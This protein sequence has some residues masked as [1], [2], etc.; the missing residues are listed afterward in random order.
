MSK[1]NF[2]WNNIQI[3]WEKPYDYIVIINCPPITIFPDVSNAILFQ[4]EPN[5][6][7]NRYMWGDWAEPPP[8]TFKYA[9][10][11]LH[12]YNNIEWHI[13]KTYTQLSEET[14]VKEQ[15][16][17]HI[18]STVLS[19][20]YKDP[21]HIKRIDFMKFLEKKGFNNVHVFGGN[22]FEWKNYM[23]SLPY[24]EKD[25]A[26]LPYK[27]VFNAENYEIRNYFTEKIV[28]GILSE[29]LVFYWGCPNIRDFIDERAYI[30]L[31]LTNF[32]KDFETIRSAIYNNEWEK[33]LPYIKSA[34]TK[35]LN[36][37]QFFPRL[38]R[39]LS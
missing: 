26:L 34:K 36:E 14:I 16:I 23:G 27:Y 28:D 3:V 1:G 8:G 19:D 31:E 38:E 9:G 37:T 10:T 13:S 20:K 39:I 22:K 4:M 6:Y 7:K 33:R 15:H 35:I 2:T 17:A 32:E 5:M 11:H 30:K 12:D 24:H 21:G 18:L 25:N 29:C